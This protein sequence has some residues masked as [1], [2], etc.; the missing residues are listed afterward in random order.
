[1]KLHEWMYELVCEVCY[2]KEYVYA[3]YMRHFGQLMKDILEQGRTCGSGSYEIIGMKSDLKVMLNWQLERCVNL[4]GL[5]VVSIS[6]EVA[7]VRT[8][9]VEL[10]VVRSFELSTGDEIFVN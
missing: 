10:H 8:G 7:S 2:D 3:C 5:N 1:M 4:I 9:K 6:Y